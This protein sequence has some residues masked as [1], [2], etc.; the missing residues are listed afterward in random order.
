MIITGHI[1]LNS[2]ITYGKGNNGIYYRFI[3]HSSN[4]LYV[5]PYKKENLRSTINVYAV[6]KIP[7]DPKYLNN[8]LILQKV[9][10]IGPVGSKQSEYSYLL[11]KHM[12]IEYEDKKQEKILIQE[13]E[14]LL[15][16]RTQTVNAFTIDPEN[17]K[18]YD[19]AFSYQYNENVHI[20]GVHIAD[21][22]S[23]VKQ[24]CLTD[25][26]AL[27]RLSSV[28][29]DSRYNNTINMLPNFLS[30]NYL[31]LKED[32][33]LKLTVSF[34]YHY[35]IINNVWTVISVNYTRD[36]VL[37]TRNYSYKEAKKELKSNKNTALKV[38]SEIANSKG[39]AHNLVSYWMIRV[40]NYVSN[41][42][43]EKNNCIILRSYKTKKD[44]YPGYLT[45]EDRQ[46]YVQ[47]TNRSAN[48]ILLKDKN[49]YN[50]EDHS[51]E[52]LNKSYYT[53]F[54]SP[55]RRYSDII[56]HRLLFEEDQNYKKLLT[57][58]EN[59]NKKNKVLNKL[60]RD[61][62]KLNLIYKLEQYW[63][64]TKEPLYL[65]GIVFS[66]DETH[67]NVKITYDQENYILSVKK[68]KE[69]KNFELVKLE[70]V[71]SINSSI[72]SKKIFINML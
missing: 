10:I 32:T 28:Y 41:K 30:E 52:S 5:I 48:Y 53:H 24:D 21:V 69:V 8:A 12:L 18:D 60:K 25:N 6:A 54:T 64:E 20:I 17:S 72:F 35:K 40:N 47:V 71:P 65:I 55:L 26:Q 2:K 11:H 15:S 51:H 49:E 46:L 9:K 4:N 36:K 45:D 23:I 33:K 56:A 31:S 7:E 27:Q 67:T 62:E 39:D 61:E 70:I 16:E 13:I 19:D 34:Y 50:E 57:V 37:I 43:M 59:I 68:S 63:N 29:P 66:Y 42:L 3:D 14:K 38:L 1:V 58:T 44:S 22:S